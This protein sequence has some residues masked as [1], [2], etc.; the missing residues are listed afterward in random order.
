MM[1]ETIIIGGGPA[2]LTAAIYLGRYNVQ[3]LLLTDMFGGQTSIAGI[4]ENYPGFDEIKGFELIAK[5]KQKAESLE[6]ITAKSGEKVIKV[7]PQ[8]GF[9]KAVTEKGEYEGKTILIAS[10]MRHR[11]LGLKGEEGLIGRGLSYCAT[12]DGMFAKDKDT[13]IIGGGYAASEAVLILEKIA[14]SVTLINIGEKL[15]G[16]TV[17]LKKI[18]NNSKIKTIQNAQTKNILTSENV[19]SAVEYQDIKTNKMLQI[20]AQMVFVEI[21][22]VPNTENFKGLVDLNEKGEI[23]I[24]QKTGRSSALGVFAAGDVSD[25]PAK[26]TV[27]ACGEGAKTAISINRYLHQAN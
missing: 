9:F 1:Y 18:E 6:T 20:P 27:V 8:D 10:G 21:G 11:N 16:E 2:A 15:S 5:M 24:N 7:E 4:I 25:M 13:V 3:T 26:Q 14:K 23:V 12:C 17:T 22:Q 19:V